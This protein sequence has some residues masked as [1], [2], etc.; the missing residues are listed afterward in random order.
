MM[1]HEFQSTLPRE[2]RHHSIYS[3]Q[4]AFYFNPRSHERS[5]GTAPDPSIIGQV[6]FNPRSHE[7]SDPLNTLNELEL[8]D[9]NPRSHERSDYSWFLSHYHKYISIHAPTRGATPSAYPSVV[10]SGNFNP[11][12]HERSD[13]CRHLLEKSYYHFNPRSHERSDL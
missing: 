6:D 1:R 13:L 7:R 9:F 11:R 3:V 10:T 12:S 5:D 2:E 4:L 8:N